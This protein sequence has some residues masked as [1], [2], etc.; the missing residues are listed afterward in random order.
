MA[1]LES[2]IEKL[3]D[4]YSLGTIDINKIKAKMKPLSDEKT[5]LEYELEHIAKPSAEISKEE[6]KS[7][8]DMFEETL[9][10]GDN[11]KLQNIISEL[12]DHI[13]IDGEDIR[14][15]WNF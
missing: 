11:Y 5:S 14:I 13:D 15:H 2:Q 8:V 6:I 10:S 7:L 12:I 9:A 1:Q 4:L 3:M